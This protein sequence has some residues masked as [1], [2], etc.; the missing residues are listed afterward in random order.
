[1]SLET[2]WRR[3]SPALAPLGWVWG[4]LMLAR[5]AAYRAGFFPSYR[6]RAKVL[7]VGNLTLGGE[8]KTPLVIWLARFLSKYAKVA[9]LTRGYGGRL[10]GP[11]LVGLGERPLFSAAE[12]GDEAYLLAQ[13]AGVPVMLAR[14]RV[15]GAFWA[16]KECEAEVLL[17]DDGF[18]HLRLERDLDLVLFSAASDPLR[19]RIFPAGRLREPVSVLTEASAFVITKT[20]LL[21]E[22]LSLFGFL[23]RFDLP[24]FRVPYVFGDPYLLNEPGHKVSRVSLRQREVIAF[25][26]LAQ[27]ESFFQALEGEGLVVVER[28]SFPDHHRYGPRDV[29]RLRALQRKWKCPLVTTEKDAVKLGSFAAE[30][31]P[32]YVFPLDPAPGEDFER[33]ILERLE[34]RPSCRH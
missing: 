6:P 14:D 19:E 8:G 17:L 28:L 3:I 32:C 29:E 16:Q 27:G 21:V 20:N 30:L 23:K 7:S 26:G 22:N 13:R 1:M 25:C 4:R 33:F 10:R 9:I 15:A 31:A 2:F 12:I 11:V 34:L 5:R 18:Q 24:V